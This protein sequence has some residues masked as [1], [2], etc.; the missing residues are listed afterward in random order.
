MH[1]TT[2]KKITDPQDCDVCVADSPEL[3]SARMRR[4]HLSLFATWSFP[5]IHF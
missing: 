3:M 2:R 5:L 4:L 1:F